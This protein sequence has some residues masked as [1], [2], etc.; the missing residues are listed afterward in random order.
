MES[1]EKRKQQR[2][3]LRTE[4]AKADAVSQGLSEDDIAAKA[5]DIDKMTIPQ[6][7]AYAAANG[8]TI[9]DTATKSAEIK[10]YLI[11]AKTAR[12]SNG[13]EGD[14]PAGWTGN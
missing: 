3:D 12:E 9:P 5:G 8:Y 10:E 6:L 2:A 14:K 13:G 4:N 1:L 7:N 11:N